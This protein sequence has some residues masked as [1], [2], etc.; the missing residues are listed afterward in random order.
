MTAMWSL[1]KS[2][3]L[4][5]DGISGCI[6]KLFAENLAV[7]LSVIYTRCFRDCIFPIQWK[8]ENVIPI[9]KPDGSFRPISLLPVPGK[10]LEKL[11]VK[12]LLLPLMKSEFDCRQFAFIPR[13]W[14]GCNTTNY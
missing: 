9:P 8:T 12:K 6:Y 2:S 1:G 13:P 11:I 14:C 5:V 7:P 4:S 10:V 3:V